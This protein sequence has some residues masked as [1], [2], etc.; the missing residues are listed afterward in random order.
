MSLPPDFL[1]RPFAHRAL[2]DRA[3]GRIENSPAA[4]R[5]AV[6]AGYGIEID[7]QPSADGVAMVF[8][9]PTLD[10][11]TGES[12]PVRARS[13][14]ELGQIALAGGDDT[15]PTL[16]AVVDMVAARVPLLVEIKDTSGDLGPT[17]GV[18]E[19]AVARVLAGRDRVAVMSFN[20]HSM[21][22][23][24]D[25]APDLPRGLT[26]CAFAEDD[27][28]QVPE[29]R[30]RHL[31]AIADYDAVGACFVSHRHVELDMARVAE[32]KRAGAAVLC[33]TVRAAAEEAAA[34]R[35][36]DAITFEGYRPGAEGGAA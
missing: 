22:R 35:V 31:A 32:L 16:D 24:R 17:D 8:H 11:L 25:L 1:A 27:W 12:G 5:A 18:L 7:V 20:P 23:M 9:D 30:R 28:P 10:R 36:A 34:L 19:H 4:V 2:H 14:A 6:D 3:T 15:I 21:A 29:T 33:W 13:A 26:T